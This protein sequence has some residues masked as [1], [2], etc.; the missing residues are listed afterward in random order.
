MIAT[1]SLRFPAPFDA[2]QC[3]GG[4][5]RVR[6]AEAPPVTVWLRGDGPPADI[7]RCTAL[8]IA[9]PPGGG[10]VVTV[11]GP[12]GETQVPTTAAF[13]HEELEGLYT[14]LPLAHPEPGQARF[15]RRVFR[16]IRVPGGRFVLAWLARRASRGRK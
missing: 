8:T 12:D 13:I 2:A 14:A 6:P 16:V 4:L 1:T 15:W 3:G 7:A 9:W 11:S 10:L 5:W